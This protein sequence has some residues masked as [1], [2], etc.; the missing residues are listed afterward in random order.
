MPLL[1][2]G[3]LLA[4]P[5]SPLD[6]LAHRDQAHVV[7]VIEAGHQKLQGRGRVIDRRRD[8]GEDG[9]EQRPQTPALPFG[10]GQGDAGLGVGVEHRELELLVG[11][12][13]VDEQVV[14]LVQDLGDAPVRAVDLVDH[15]DGGEPLLQGLAQ[16]EAGLGQR[17]FG[18]VH[19]QH[20]PVHQVQGALHLAAEIGVARG[21]DDVDLHPFVGD[22]HVLGHD[23]DAL[24]P[25]QVHA[26][27]HPFDHLLVFPEDAALPEHGIRQGGLAVVHVGDNGDISQI[28]TNLH[29]NLRL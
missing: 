8:G 18:G 11:G 17:P 20:D 1:Q 14:D 5:I 29:N 24:F 12:V 9:V 2:E 27:H 7:A 3:H 6:D 15:H 16:D 19:Q 25:L 13:Q 21:V 26:V 23:G 10:V 28:F 4:A 22:G